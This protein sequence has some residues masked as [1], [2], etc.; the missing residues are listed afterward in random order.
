MFTRFNSSALA[1]TIKVEPA[2]R[3]P[4]SS[5]ETPIGVGNSMPES[6]WKAG[7]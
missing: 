4:S 3:K 6:R 1:T 5:F 2:S 7:A